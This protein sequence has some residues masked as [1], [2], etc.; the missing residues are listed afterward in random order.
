ML[1]FIVLFDKVDLSEFIM[2]N[3]NQKIK[4]NLHL[5]HNLRALR[6]N[7]GLTQEQVITKMQLMGFSITRSSYSKIECGISNISVPELLALKDLYQASFEEIF[8][9][10]DN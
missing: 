6:K 10:S 8:K 7:A 2:E 1:Q 9:L 3:S 4:Y 5:G